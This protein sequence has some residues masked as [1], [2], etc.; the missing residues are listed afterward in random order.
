MKSLLCVKQKLCMKSISDI[1][2]VGQVFD[3]VSSSAKDDGDPVYKLEDQTGV[4][5]Y[6]LLR[7]VPFPWSGISLDALHNPSAD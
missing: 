4:H 2:M 5:I 1:G 6:L 3:K 7:S